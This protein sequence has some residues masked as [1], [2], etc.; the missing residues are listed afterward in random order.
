MAA[1]DR[2]GARGTGGLT[3][4]ALAASC[5]PLSLPPRRSHR[6]RVLRGQRH[7]FQLYPRRQDVPPDARGGRFVPGCRAHVSHT[8]GRG[9]RNR[10]ARAAARGC[11]RVR[12]G[13]REAGGQQWRGIDADGH[14]TRPLRF[15]HLFAPPH[16]A[17]RIVAQDGVGG[18]LWRGLR[19]RILANGLQGLL[20]SVVS[21]G[22]EGGGARVP[23]VGRGCRPRRWTSTRPRALGC[24]AGWAPVPR[25]DPVA[26]AAACRRG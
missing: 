21:G 6:L 9:R 24:S 18:L 23:V 1:H 20:F 17:R 7:A 26:A 16:P 4:G 19:T 8:A 10:G 5:P 22:G 25:R 13:G 3:A 12:H 2:A 14:P 15:S 11:A